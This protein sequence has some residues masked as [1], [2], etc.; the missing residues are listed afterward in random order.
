MRLPEKIGFLIFK[1]WGPPSAAA[2]FFPTAQQ[3]ARNIAKM[4]FAIASI[5]A[6]T[7]RAEEPDMK[8]VVRADHPGHAIPET[9]YGIFFEDINYAADGGIYAERI[10]N[11]GF[12]WP[13]P[14]MEAWQKDYRGGGMARLSRQSGFPL[15]PNTAQYLRIEVI[16]PGKDKAGVG[17]ANGGFGGIAV[18]QGAAYD[19]SFHARP[20]RGYEGGLT[21]A[22]ESKTGGRLAS[23][24][25]N[26]GDWKNRQPAQ[27]PA[28]PLAPGPLADWVKYTAELKPAATVEDARLVVLCDAP[29]IVDLE[30]VSLFPRDTYKRRLNGLR[31]DLVELLKAMKPGSMRFPGGC[32]VEGTDLNNLYDWKR[33]VGPIE[34]RPVNHN[35]WGY[36]QSGG[37]GFFEYFQ[38]AEDI[39]A[40]PLPILAAGMSCQFRKSEMVPLGGLDR[41]IQDALDLIEFANGAPT[42]PWG[43]VRA[44]MGHP[45]PFKL[46]MLGIGNENWGM[47]F[48]DRY[49]IIYKGIKAK[50]PEIEIVSSA[51]AGP[52]GR[53]YDLAWDKIPKIGAQWIDEH[54]YVSAD[55]LFNSTRRYDKFNRNGPKVYVGEYACHLPDRANNLYAALAEAA[56]MTGFERNSDIVGMTAYAP[57]FNKI[58]STQWVPDLIWFTN[59]RSYGTPSYHV[60]KLFGNHRPDVLLPTEA[61]VVSKPMPPAGRIGLQTWLTSA[62]FKDIRVTRES[63][64]LY[65][66]DPARKLAGWS[67]PA[68]GKWHVV[69]GALRQT[70]NQVEKT[71]ISTG[72][73]MWQDYTVRLKARKLGGAEGFIVRVRDQ[74]NQFVHVNFGGWSN[75]AHGIEQN[76]SNP[77]V[78]KPG[79]IETNR[80]YDVEISLAGDRVSASLDGKKLF[81]NVIAPSGTA[82]GVE[83]VSGYDKKVGEI[84]IKCVNPRTEPCV[85]RLNVAGASVPA[86]EARRITL[87]GDPTAINDL[88][89]PSRIAPIEDTFAVTGPEISI[90]LQPSSLTILRCKARLAK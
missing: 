62:E 25:L 18:K 23:F 76:G 46:R 21:V 83:I 56:M 27:A 78:Q 58:G 30:F 17:V 15:H 28:S 45:A 39:G 48:I 74:G 31:A 13:T 3:A 2:R 77:I 5:A 81:E 63:K 34:G 29:G 32:I 6:G 4:S 52:A 40:S 14:E 7:A 82:P 72:D 90:K 59:T 36:W 42:T 19:L 80:W 84:V 73:P 10:A 55:W 87:A 9:L 61:N 86:Q 41:V 37:L 44:D 89:Q 85:L 66:F 26:P 24:R 12:D 47:D 16:H 57:L 49:G 60:Q 88:E 1:P 68:D 79:K 8:A 20:H 38:L 70:D 50:H 53:N 65:T 54:Y 33:T 11:R 64:D 75:T 43:K 22:L 51:G 71:H 67:P 35:L 69:D